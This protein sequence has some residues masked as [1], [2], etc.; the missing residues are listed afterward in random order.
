MLT[1]YIMHLLCLNSLLYKL[2][3]D[4]EHIYTILGDLITAS[5]WKE[6][7]E[8]RKVLVNQYCWD[9]ESGQYFDYNYKTKSRRVYPFASTFFPLWAGLATEEQAKR[10]S[11]NLHILERDGG[12]LTSTNASGCQWDAP[13]GWAPLQWLAV[14]GLLNYNF[15]TEAHRIARKFTNLIIKNFE[16]DHNIVEKYDV[17]NCSSTVQVGYGYLENEVGF[18]WT[19]AIFVEMLHVLDQ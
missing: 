15:K 5:M 9:E 3:K 17:E 6:R 18:G 8:K 7:A 11:Q 2:E 1:L 12:I 10:I 13:Y 19:N 14:K 4:M 16:R